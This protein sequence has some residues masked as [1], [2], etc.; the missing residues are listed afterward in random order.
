LVHDDGSRFEN[1]LG[2]VLYNQTKFFGGALGEE[3]DAAE[4][5]NGGLCACHVHKCNADGKAC[6][7]LRDNFSLER[8]HM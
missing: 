2:G 8:S 5:I 6:F 3:S 1:T 4:M 7:S